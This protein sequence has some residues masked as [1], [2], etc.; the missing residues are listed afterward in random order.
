M[1][2]A[3]ALTIDKPVATSPSVNRVADAA[4]RIVGYR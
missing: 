2:L 4:L 1:A 3:V